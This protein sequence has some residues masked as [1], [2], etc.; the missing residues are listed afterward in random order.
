MNVRDR[1]LELVETG[2]LSWEDVAQALLRAMS[3]DDLQ[4]VVDTY[5]W[6]MASA[7]SNTLTA[8]TQS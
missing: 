5:G 4:D 6:D 2:S 7:K 3:H 8:R 1:I